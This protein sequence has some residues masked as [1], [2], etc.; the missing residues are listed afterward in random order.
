MFNLNHT[1][2]YQLTMDI[3]STDYH[4]LIAYNFQGYKFLWNKESCC[5]V[6]KFLRISILYCG[7]IKQVWQGDKDCDKVSILWAFNFMLF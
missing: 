1:I 5:I 4:N 6:D 3:I 7:Q 2:I